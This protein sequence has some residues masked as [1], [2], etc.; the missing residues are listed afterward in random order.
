[1]NTARLQRKA[2]TQENLEKTFGERKM[3]SGLHAHVEKDEGGS[4][5]KNWVKTSGLWS[6]LHW[7]HQGISP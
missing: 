3:D 6:M 4:T 5:R 7:K 2:A 1:V